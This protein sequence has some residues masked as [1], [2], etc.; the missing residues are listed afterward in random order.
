VITEIEIKIPPEQLGDA[1]FL[2]NSCAL[3]LGVEP[4]AITYI[5]PEKRS[6]DAR[7]SYPFYRLIAKVFVGEN[8]P[9]APP[10]IH[11]PVLPP[12]APKTIIVGM[13]PGGLFAALR[14]IELGIKPIIIERGKDHQSRRK[15]LKAIQQN[16]FVNPDSNY[17]FGEG[18]AGTYSDGKLYTRANK[19]GNIKKILQVFIQ[20]GAEPDIAVDAHPHIGSNRL[21]KIVH[22][23][24]D[25]ILSS[26]GEVH[27][28]ERI[29]GLL[30]EHGKVRGVHTASRE[31]NADSVI[32][33]TGHSARDVFSFLSKQNL[34]LENKPFA[35]GV[36]IEHPQALINDI[37]YHGSGGGLPNAA[38]SEA[39][40]V[41]DRGVYS[42]CMCPGGIIIPAATVQG[43]IVVNGM[44]MAKRDSLYA[45]S[46]FV[47]EVKEEDWKPF[48][49]TS[50]LPGVALQQSLE[51][52]AFSLAG[53]TQ[54]A[55]AQRISDFVRHRLS[56]DLPKTSYIPGLTSTPLHETLPLFM[57]DRIK[58]AIFHFDGKMPGYLTKEAQI[59]AFESR[60]SSPIRIP[61]DAETLM[62]PDAV[63]LFPCAEGAGYA[64]GIVSA[65]MDGE[66]C[67][68]A[69]K[70]FL[71]V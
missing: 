53:G 39:T 13:G 58:K 9:E 17:C 47:V 34:R 71:T 1:D 70:Q 6:I 19:R 59:V 10:P 38:Y 42:F 61:R 40:Q 50:T 31:W 11:Y 52:A 18:G 48:E 14:L 4:S 5:K 64:G 62:H 21:Y 37:R 68:E 33:A 8:V 67:A 26:G 60:T 29:T 55:P 44:S 66:K 25:T 20:F 22:R 49:K 69:T 41:D 46:G 63:G 16:N 51:Q 15:D 35:M 30:L 32:L 36:R 65:A 54:K 28:N 43:E 2:L 7:S 24:R 56:N 12:N 3:R 23:M 27:F 45:N 57:A